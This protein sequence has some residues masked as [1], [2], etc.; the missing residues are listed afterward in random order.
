MY[1]YIYTFIYIYV[2]VCVCVSDTSRDKNFIPWLFGSANIYYFFSVGL[3]SLKEKNKINMDQENINSHGNKFRQQGQHIISGSILKILVPSSH[4]LF[5]PSS[6]LTFDPFL[7]FTQCSGDLFFTFCTDRSAW[8][9]L[10]VFSSR[11]HFVSTLS[12][13]LPIHNIIGF[14]CFLWK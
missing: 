6:C 1:I 11:H 8:G 3:S 4:Y 2:F 14:S 12:R 7:I 10:H 5:F 13:L 9:F